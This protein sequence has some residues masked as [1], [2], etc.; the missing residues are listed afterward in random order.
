MS[1][2]SEPSGGEPPP[3][4]PMAWLGQDFGVRLA[5]AI[6]MAAI[7]AGALI[8]G[9]HP[10]DLLVFVLALLLS[11]EWARL[12]HGRGADLVIAV[13][14]GATALAVGLAAL[15]F[16]GLGLLTLPIG[17]ILATLLSLG[18][19]GLFAAL[20]VFY[21]GLPA[22]TLIWLRSDPTYGLRAAVFVILVVIA[23]D[24][25]ALLAGRGLGG[26]KLWPGVS[27]NKTWAGLIGGVLAG[28]M[29][30]A[31]MVFAVPGGAAARLGAMAA[32]LAFL[33]QIGDLMESAIKR[34]FGA[35]D[36]SRLIPGHG[37][38]MD[39]VDGLVI[40]AAAAG[41]VGFFLNVHSPARA[42]LMGY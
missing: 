28:A 20:G 11:W 36:T 13:H 42:L 26:P 7:A 23:A 19:H 30:G 16:V 9:R 37:G 21:A 2:Q 34:R 32:A 10:F 14:I 25:G 3:R 39:R 35:K 22:V 5:S 8:A 24:T 4:T 6:A 31:L 27:P 18:R 17:A 12:V 41:L 1:D 33:A 38:I 15:D 40:A 29:A